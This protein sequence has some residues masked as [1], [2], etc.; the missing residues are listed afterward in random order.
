MQDK[1]LVDIMPVT[2]HQIF[3]SLQNY[4]DAATTVA[5]TIH[6][7]VAPIAPLAKQ[8]EFSPENFFPNLG[9]AV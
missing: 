1:S 6:R 8:I 3:K 2:R 5:L 9:L 7:R 4:S